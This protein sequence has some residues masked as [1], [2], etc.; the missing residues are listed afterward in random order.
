MEIAQLC[1]GIR[2]DNCSVNLASGKWNQSEL[3]VYV[4]VYISSDAQHPKQRIIYFGT[5]CK[6]MKV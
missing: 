1:S 4:W 2:E 3:P 6:I 5:N